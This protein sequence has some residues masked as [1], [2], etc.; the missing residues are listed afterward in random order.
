[1]I[2]AQ[3]DCLSRDV[4]FIAG[5]IAQRVPF[6][7]AEQGGNAPPFM[8]H[9]HAALVDKERTLLSQ[10][11]RAA[12]QARKAAGM[13][14]GNRTNLAT[15]TKLANHASRQVADRFAANVLPL[16]EEIRAD[17]VVSIKRIAVALNARGVRTAGG[18][19]WYL[20]TVKNLLAR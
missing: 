15:A 16:V 18:G 20:T 2:V 10:R 4:A 1:M 12:L 14:L 3:L 6:I 13:K 9:L 19:Q 11:T 5:L 7:V 17:G 8:L